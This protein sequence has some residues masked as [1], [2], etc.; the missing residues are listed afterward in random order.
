MGKRKYPVKSNRRLFCRKCNKAYQ[1]AEVEH[2]GL[3]NG[4]WYKCPE[5]DSR[6]YLTPGKGRGI[7]WA[8]SNCGKEINNVRLRILDYEVVCP[9]CGKPELGPPPSN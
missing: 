8:C 4:R 6:L 2:G 9:K 5:C 7:T 3:I 1:E